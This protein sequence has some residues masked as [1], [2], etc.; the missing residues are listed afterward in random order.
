MKTYRAH[1]RVEFE[2]FSPKD[3]VFIWRPNPFRPRP[4][5]SDFLFI[6]EFYTSARHQPFARAV[7]QTM[8][9]DFES[10]LQFD[11]EYDADKPECRLWPEAKPQ[12]IE[13]LEKLNNLRLELYVSRRDKP[14]EIALVCAAWC[15]YGDGDM[16]S[17]ETVRPCYED[18]M[19]LRFRG[20][21]FEDNG[22]VHFD[23]QGGD[24][25]HDEL[26]G[27]LGTPE[28]LADYF[29]LF[30]RGRQYCSRKKEAAV[31][32]GE[33]ARAGGPMSLLECEG[34]SLID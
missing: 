23:L 19:D 16:L 15:D 32:E 2:V 11:G 7:G 26:L 10:H 34:Q 9:G 6:A 4:Q 13:E 25:Y 8:F 22:S 1:R 30:L 18:G 14:D 12:V 20:I 21:V 29:D 31:E 3:A 17:F 24:A 33:P 27:F 28:I 5:L